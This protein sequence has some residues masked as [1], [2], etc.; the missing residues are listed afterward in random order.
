MTLI[1]KQ[2]NGM[3]NKMRKVLDIHDLMQYNTLNNFLDGIEEDVDVNMVGHP[4]ESS[5]VRLDDFDKEA[6]KWYEKQDEK[7]A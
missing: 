5:Y 2:S 4:R 6:V 3:K 7:S 1:K